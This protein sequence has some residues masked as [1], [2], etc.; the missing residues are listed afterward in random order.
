M[1]VG[2]ENA[3]LDGI[4]FLDDD[5]RLEDGLLGELEESDADAVIIPERSLNRNVIGRLMDRKRKYLEA[6]VRES[7][8]PD[9]GVIPRFYKR[10]LLLRAFENISIR[11]LRVASQHEDTILYNEV[12]KKCKKVSM[13][14]KRIFNQDPS[15]AKFIAK[16]FEYGKQNE[17][18]LSSGALTAEQID[19]IRRMDRNR[20]IYA[21]DK[22]LNPGLL[23]DLLKG[24]PY[25]LG[26]TICSLK[27]LFTT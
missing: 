4:L 25:V 7:P 17:Q 24:P 26:S 1:R 21:T 9:V 12:Y 23:I 11:T 8:R 3:N 14:Q 5:Q 6:L 15:L 20:M 22:G 13:S 10:N 2:A 16:A 27:S 18:A 19:L